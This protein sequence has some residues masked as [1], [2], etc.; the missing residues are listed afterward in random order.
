MGLVRQTCCT[1]QYNRCKYNEQC[2]FSIKT[3]VLQNHIHVIAYKSNAFV[4]ANDF[5]LVKGLL[6]GSIEMTFTE[7]VQPERF[8][9]FLLSLQQC[10]FFSVFQ[11]GLFQATNNI[12]TLGEDVEHKRCMPQRFSVGFHI[13]GRF[14]MNDDF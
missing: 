7:P 14:R 4:K 12:Q 5:Y 9:L 1:C 3:K 6:T 11:P 2:I 10:E 8:Q 13:H